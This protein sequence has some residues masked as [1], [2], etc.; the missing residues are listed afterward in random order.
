MKVL[1]HLLGCV[2]AIVESIWGDAGRW[3]QVVED[4]KHRELS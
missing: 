4:L 1:W 3:L 2:R